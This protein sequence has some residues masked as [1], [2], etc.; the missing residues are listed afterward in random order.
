MSPNSKLCEIMENCL[1]GLCM[2]IPPN[3]RIYEHE[4]AV[5]DEE[6]D[7]EW[8]TNLGPDVEFDPKLSEIIF[9]LTDTS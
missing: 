6:R 7:G 5:Y 4:D 8:G 2:S 3:F 1:L 9:S